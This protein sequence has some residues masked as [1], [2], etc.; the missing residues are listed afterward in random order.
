[1]C[2]SKLSTVVSSGE[3]STD[4]QLQSTSAVTG[5]S[6]ASMPS[7][8]SRRGDIPQIRGGPH[9]ASTGSPRGTGDRHGV[10]TAI[11]A[12]IPVA[13]PTPVINATG[14]AVAEFMSRSCRMYRA[15]VTLTSAQRA[16]GMSQPR[17]D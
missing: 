13:R 1:M 3:E 16:V 10:L 6:V 9:H 17:P 14:R 2:R 12:Q 7:K 11:A 5:P 8:H 4:S 15:Q